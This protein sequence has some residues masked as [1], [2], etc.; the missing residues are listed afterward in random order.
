MRLTIKT[1]GTIVLF[2]LAA[3]SVLGQAPPEVYSIVLSPL[4]DQAVEIE[5][6]GK[7]MLFEENGLFL[8][9]RQGANA[10]EPDAKLILDHIWVDITLQ[11]E[12]EEVRLFTDSVSISING[13]QKYYPIQTGTSYYS[14]PGGASEVFLTNVPYDMR[15]FFKRFDR[16]LSSDILDI[17]LYLPPIRSK[18]G[19]V[20]MEEKQIKL[21]GNIRGA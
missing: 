12:S 11:T 2:S 10:Y 17:T 3:L 6:D 19:A 13:T 7:T 9:I 16:E 21:Q 18:N 20:L 1:L 5:S 4:E 14:L 8:E 15:L